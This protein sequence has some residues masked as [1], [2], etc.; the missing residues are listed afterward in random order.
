MAQQDQFVPN[1]GNQWYILY[2][3]FN[4]GNNVIFTQATLF[5]IHLNSTIEVYDANLDE[6]LG[7]Y[8]VKLFS[9]TPYAFSTINNNVIFYGSDCAPCDAFCISVGGGTGFVKYINYNGQE[10]T[11]SLP[12]KICTKSKPFVS[13]STPI[14]KPAGGECTSIAGCDIS[15]FELTNCSTG[16]I[17]YSNNQSLFTAYANNKTVT[18]NEL[19]G[20]WTVALG[21]ECT[22]FEDVS[23]KLS[24][25]SCK[26]VCQ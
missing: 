22:C 15:C 23:I 2:P 24:Y 4:S 21:Y 26:H 10:V 19:D 17:I 18:L 20:C 3:C 16:Q 25:S 11:T 1:T 5:N 7:C 8:T 9:G 13:I 6:F 12:A 14:I